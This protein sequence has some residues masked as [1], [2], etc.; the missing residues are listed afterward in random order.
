MRKRIYG[1]YDLVKRRNL[2]IR[3]RTRVSQIA[4]T[5]MQAVK[6]SYYSNNMTTF[7]NHTGDPKRLIN[8]YE[9]NVYLN[10]M[11]ICTVHPK[12]E[13]T[14]AANFGGTTPTRFTLAVTV[15]MN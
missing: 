8:M 1:V 6:E 3:T 13:R 12:G 7:H 10:C 9:N 11:S 2:P 14:V 15:A 4:G 5:G